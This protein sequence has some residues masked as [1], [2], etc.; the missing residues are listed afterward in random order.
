L[1]THPFALAA[2]RKT[3]QLSECSIIVIYNWS[4]P[5][6]LLHLDLAKID[7]IDYSLQI[8]MIG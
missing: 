4:R 5:D 8:R 7:R 6:S 3:Q 2:F 1:A